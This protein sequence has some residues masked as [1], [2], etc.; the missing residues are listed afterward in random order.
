MTKE[1]FLKK[2]KDE[3]PKDCII[4]LD[5]SYD[6]QN[7]SSIYRYNFIWRG[8]KWIVAFRTMDDLVYDNVIQ[9]LWRRIGK[10]L[11]EAQK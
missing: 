7:D 6:L 9:D 10:V 2:L 8:H 4:S 5:E 1:E 3:L 11:K